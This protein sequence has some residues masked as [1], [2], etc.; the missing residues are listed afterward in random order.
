[1]TQTSVKTR[2]KFD[3]T[4]KREAVN[5]WLASRKSAEVVA[6]ELGISANRLYAWKQ[7]FAPAA[8]G[9]RG[10]AGAAGGEWGAGAPRCWTRNN[11]SSPR[12]GGGGGR[13]GG[14]TPGPPA[15]LQSQ[16]N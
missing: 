12:A 6:E 14:K 2:R 16:L 11:P 7:R 9:G 1:M 13:G 15:D 10:A 4:F 3:E 8:A 5:N